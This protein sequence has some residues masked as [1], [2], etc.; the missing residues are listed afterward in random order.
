MLFRRGAVAL[1][2]VA[3]CA[4][5]EDEA[6]GRTRSPLG[7]SQG[8]FC[9]PGTTPDLTLG[10][11]VDDQ[12]AYGPFTRAMTDA[13]RASGGG[14][15]CERA[16]T[17]SIDGKTVAVPRWGR[18]LAT[19][20]RGTGDCMKG[21][22]R[23]PTLGVCVEGQDAFGPFP[24]YALSA[25][26]VKGGGA[27]CYTNRWGK[28]FYAAIAA[29]PSPRFDAT[30]TLEYHEVVSA[31]DGSLPPSGRVSTGHMTRLANAY[32]PARHLVTFDDGYTNVYSLA[33]PILSARKV[34]AVAAIVVE[35]T[36]DSGSPD[37]LANHMSRAELTGLA[38]AGWSLALHAGT[39]A[40]H[41]LHYR[42]EAEIL[43]TGDVVSASR[44]PAAVPLSDARA[45]AY[46][47]DATRLPGGPTARLHAELLAER[48]AVESRVAGGERLEQATTAVLAA[49]L[50][51][52]RTRL[53]ELSG[54]P[55]IAIDTF[56]YPHSESDAVVRAA[57][58]RAGFARAYAGGPI[59]TP[60]ATYDLPRR[61]MNDRTAIP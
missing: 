44:T 18:A 43:L 34:P 25:C 49:R 29:V 47:A 5:G 26:V 6:V 51:R 4:S 36:R 50:E 23:D 16:L 52:Q 2:L 8:L 35:A 45:V 19:R 21:A 10:F 60:G 46:L 3:A 39:V 33:L 11:C 31:P 53:A 20:L 9:P 38:R 42:R 55:K 28:V 7:A 37:A 17:F 1:L 61:W 12:N 15:A 13:C 56:V 24:V 30:H 32:D 22:Q 59:G 58:A 48:A 41:E 40:E 57:A 14:S 54:V 27:A